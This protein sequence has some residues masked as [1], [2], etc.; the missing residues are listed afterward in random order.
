MASTYRVL[1]FESCFQTVLSK[2]NFPM[3]TV[4]FRKLLSCVSTLMRDTDISNLY[5]CPSVCLSVR[6]V[7][8]SDETA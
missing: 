3:C 5:V 4:H 6:D 7:P 8:V 2:V 1:Y